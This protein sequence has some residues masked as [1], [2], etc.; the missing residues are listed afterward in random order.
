MLM[1]LDS[2]EGNTEE[3]TEILAN[4]QENAYNFVDKQTAIL[5]AFH[6]CQSNPKWTYKF[7]AGHFNVSIQNIRT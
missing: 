2:I 3:D 5:D 1:D 6:Y 4:N 7:V